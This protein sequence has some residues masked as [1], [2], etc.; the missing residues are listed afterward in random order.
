VRTNNDQFIYASAKEMNRTGRRSVFAFASWL[1]PDFSKVRAGSEW[2]MAHL[3]RYSGST[4]EQV[5]EHFGDEIADPKQPATT[6][7][8]S[9]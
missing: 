1:P 5:A 9:W 4:D 3:G 7:H 6:T 8:V 2:N